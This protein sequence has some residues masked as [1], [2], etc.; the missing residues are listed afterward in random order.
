MKS[1]ESKW[2]RNLHYDYH[3]GVGHTTDQCRILQTFLENQ[4]DQEPKLVVKRPRSGDEHPS[5][6]LTLT[7]KE[8]MPRTQMHCLGD[9][10]V[11]RRPSCRKMLL[12]VGDGREVGLARVRGASRGR[13][14]S[15]KKYIL[16]ILSTTTTD[17]QRPEIQ[18]QQQKQEGVFIIKGGLKFSSNSKSKKRVAG[19]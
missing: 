1:D 4:I 3:K 6:S 17:A 15:S 18:Q 12:H 8:S 14:D 16:G 19:Y 13:R 10:G 2:D 9:N 11:T 5:L 7:W